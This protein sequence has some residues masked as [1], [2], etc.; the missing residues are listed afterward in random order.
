MIEYPDIFGL[1]GGLLNGLFFSW[2]ILPPAGKK[3]FTKRSNTEKCLF[4]TGLVLVIGI[5]T[6]SGMALFLFSESIKEYWSA[7]D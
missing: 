6:L 3:T 2:V 5:N 1:V 4:F 7:G